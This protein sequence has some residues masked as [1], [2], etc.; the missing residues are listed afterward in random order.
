MSEERS[1]LTITLDLEDH[2]LGG[3]PGRRYLGNATRILDFL[4]HHKV[5]A[6]VFVV[7]DLIDECRAVLRAA[8]DG[9]HELAV[10][11]ARHT[12][13]T[14]EQPATLAPLLG[15]ARAVLEDISGRAVGGFRAPVFSLTP[16][17]R[18]ITDVL[19]EQGYTY[20]SSVLPAS[21]PL[22]GYPGAP[23]T[24]F[25]WPSGVIELPVPIGHLGPLTLPFLG[26]IY[27]RYLPL[28]VIEALGKRLADNSV[29]WS[30]LHP[31]DVDSSEP[32]YRFPG[33]TVAQSLL[34]WRRRRGTLGRLHA[35]LTG[36]SLRPGAPFAELLAG[37]QAA[38]LPTFAAA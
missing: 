31:Y 22:F 10:H 27:M 18:W 19:A 1:P 6:T 20:S 9:G 38:Q 13:L 37:L 11:S 12:P 23:A 3:D 16:A 14:A 4:H 36:Q 21:N 7:G 35:L 32:F 5:R 34:L 24:P 29:R 28:V 30:Y 33:T 17:T 2:R 25:R 15:R 8:A 26:G